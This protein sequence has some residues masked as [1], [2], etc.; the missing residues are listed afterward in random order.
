MNVMCSKLDRN[1]TIKRHTRMRIENDC[2]SLRGGFQKYSG[3]RDRTMHTRTS[4]AVG[5]IHHV[6]MNNHQLLIHQIL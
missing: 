1:L 6:S 5:N 2:S 3:V 4:A